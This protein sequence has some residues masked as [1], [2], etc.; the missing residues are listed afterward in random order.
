MC[1]WGEAWANGPYLNSSMDDEEG[2]AAYTAIQ[3]AMDLRKTGTA[4]EQALIEALGTRYAAEPTEDNRVPL[5]STYADAMR[6]VVR[7]FPNDLDAA[8][9]LGEALILLAPRRFWDEDGAPNPGVDEMVA[10]LESVLARDIK[11]PG[12]CHHY[13]HLVEAS[14]APER[15]EA[16]AD[17]LGSAIPG[18]SH[19][20]H[21]PSHIYMN[22][23]RYG[24]AVTANQQAWHTDQRHAFGGPP[25]V[26]PS[27]NLHMMLFGAWLDGQSA[28]ALQAARDLAR[29]TENS[30]FYVPVTLVRFGRWDEV[31]E[32]ADAPDGLFLGGMWDFSRGMAE[33]RLGDSGEAHDYLGKVAGAIHE[34]PDSMSMN[35]RRHKQRDLL[36]MAHGILEGE[37]LAEGGDYDGATRVLRAAAL[38]EDNLSYDE[39][40][41]WPIPVR[42]I[43]GAVLLEAGE[44]EAAEVEYRKQLDHHAENGWSLYG[45]AQSLEAQGKVDRAEEVWERYEHAW[46][47]R[48]VW[49][50][51][52]RF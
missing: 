21:M 36:L 15:A 8:S 43:L 33:L 39:P 19:I 40:E 10:V 3:R 18:A 46:E 14:T 32:L 42:H 27:H 2:L 5:D 38:V 23:G 37:I 35:F 28:V 6:D 16:C 7:R 47:R 1:F 51:S 25:G 24:D 13:I 52:S 17:H 29:I 30:S 11:H 12:A 48:D 20:N 26:Y 4:I 31:L 41:P 44:P 9:L 50:R 34:L 49:M 22:I 45:L